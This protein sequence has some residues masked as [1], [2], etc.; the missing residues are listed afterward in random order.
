VCWEGEPDKRSEKRPNIHQ[1]ILELDG[2]VKPVLLVFTNVN[3][4]KRVSRR[5]IK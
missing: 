1:I 5:F 4:M 3:K 2:I